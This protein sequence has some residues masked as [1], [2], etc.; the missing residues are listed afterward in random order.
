MTLVTTVRSA[1][2]A[3]D[4]PQAKRTGTVNLRGHVLIKNRPGRRA[5][6]ALGSLTLRS[7]NRGA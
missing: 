4:Q 2:P 1:R 6:S 7:S 3:P 5:E